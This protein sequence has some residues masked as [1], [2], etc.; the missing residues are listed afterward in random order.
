M[1]AQCAVCGAYYEHALG[2][3]CS[4]RGDITTTRVFSEADP[5]QRYRDRLAWKHVIEAAK[6]SMEEQTI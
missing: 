4:V 1:S 5:V 2:C 3:S 6:R